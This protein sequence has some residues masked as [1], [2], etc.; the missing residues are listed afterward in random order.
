VGPDLLRIEGVLLVAAV[1]GEARIVVLDAAV[2]SGTCTMLA[3]GGNVWSS[4]SI[5]SLREP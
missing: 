1:A 2:V 3:V 4:R 5:S